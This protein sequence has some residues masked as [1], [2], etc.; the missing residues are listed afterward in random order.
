MPVLPFLPSIIGGLTGGIQLLTS[1]KARKQRAFEQELAKM[2]VYEGSPEIARN[3][4]QNLQRANVGLGQLESTKLA[5]REQARNLSNILS[6]AA[7]RPGGQGLVA[8]LYDRQNLAMQRTYEGAEREK[9][10]RMGEL[11]RAAQLQ[12]ADQGKIFESRRRKQADITNARA[13]EAAQAARQKES[14]LSNITSAATNAG[15]IFAAKYGGGDTSKKK[16]GIDDFDES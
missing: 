4:Q 7:S 14:A 3:Y 13:L 15:R 6:Y 1:G 8:N 5:Q 2:P 16:F 9:N 10:R 11:T 12:A